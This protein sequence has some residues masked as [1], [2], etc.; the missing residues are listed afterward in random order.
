VG[1]QALPPVLVRSEPPSNAA[2]PS[3]RGPS[4]LTAQVHTRDEIQ[5]ADECGA[6]LFLVN[7]V[8][9][10]GIEPGQHRVRDL[11]VGCRLTGRVQTYR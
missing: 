8:R 11:Q 5:L 10:T 6:A 2:V 4:L 7:E 3:G 9:R 1:G